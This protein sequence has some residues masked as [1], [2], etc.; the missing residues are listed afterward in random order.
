MG[1]GAECAGTCLRTQGCLA[2]R[3]IFA[4]KFC[5]FRN[6]NT[7]LEIKSPYNPGAEVVV[8]I[9]YDKMDPCEMNNK[10]LK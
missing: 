8:M 10:L 6:G 1:Y 4:S 7:K 2:Y 3:W 5:E 9:L